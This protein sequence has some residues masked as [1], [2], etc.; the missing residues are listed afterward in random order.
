MFDVGISAFDLSLFLF[1]LQPTNF[2]NPMY[3]RLYNE[4]TLQSADNEKNP[5]VNDGKM[6]ANFYGDE[7]RQP[8][9]H[10]SNKV[11]RLEDHVTYTADMTVMM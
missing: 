1:L 11:T 6:A 9:G 2:T 5:L 7:E 4:N 10:G 3:N 8:L